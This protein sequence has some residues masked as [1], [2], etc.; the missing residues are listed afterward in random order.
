[1]VRSAY[2][3]S[4]LPP[5]DLV[6]PASLPD[7]DPRAVGGAGP[8]TADSEPNPGIDPQAQFLKEMAARE[9]LPPEMVDEF[10]AGPQGSPSEFLERM[11]PLIHSAGTD[12]EIDMMDSL[13]DE[14]GLTGQNIGRG[15]YH[16]E[17]GPGS[18]TGGKTGI[19]GTSV[20]RE[21][22]FEPDEPTGDLDRPY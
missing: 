19:G 5:E 22:R 11:A 13:L 14:M 15:A 2:L 1:M 9:N 10:L 8:P 18:A 3:G 4:D 16:Q 21:P 17:P 20:L 6:V 7:K 12:S